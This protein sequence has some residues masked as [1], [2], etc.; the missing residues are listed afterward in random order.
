MS[1]SYYNEQW[2]HA[3]ESLNV[4]IESENPESK[5]VLSADATWDDIWQHYS[6]LYI[7]YIQIFRELEGCYD[8]MVH[9]QKRQDVK[10]ALRSV[11]ARLLLL[12]EQLKTFGFGGSKLE[13]S[14][15]YRPN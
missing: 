12:R 9:P 11:M 15:F 5:K 14:S 6:T 7:R 4:Q 10:A 3:M 2:Q 13:I 1:H 8:Q